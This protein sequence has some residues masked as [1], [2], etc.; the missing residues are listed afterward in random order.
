MLC[1][2]VVIGEDF[3][4]RQILTVDGLVITGVV[5]KETDSALTVRTATATQTIA[6]DDVEK[7]VV[8]KN[9]FM[10]EGLLKPLT[11]R[12]RIELL[13]YLMSLK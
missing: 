2:E 3:L 4:A 12:E 9:S 1:E 7:M 11:D 13:M 5:L 8:S 6:K 10:P